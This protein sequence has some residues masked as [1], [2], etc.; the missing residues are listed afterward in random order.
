M[1]SEDPYEGARSTHAPINFSTPCIRKQGLCTLPLFPDV[2]FERRRDRD[3]LL[4]RT[5]R[6]VCVRDPQLRGTLERA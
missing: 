4:G 6:Q 2:E 1:N 5:L 3:R